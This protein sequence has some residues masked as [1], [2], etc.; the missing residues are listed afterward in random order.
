MPVSLDSEL[1]GD[2]LA[3]LHDALQW[4][5]TDARWGAVAQAVHAVAEALQSGN[6]DAFRAAVYDLELAGP[7]RATGIGN[8]PIV[9]PPGPVR[10]EINELIQSM[11]GRG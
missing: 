4:R 3:V 7:V 11:G 1:R 2:A 6:A 9:P 8:T 10:E 5:L